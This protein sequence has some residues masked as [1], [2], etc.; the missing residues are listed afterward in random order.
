MRSGGSRMVVNLM[1]VSVTE[2]FIG[3]AVFSVLFLLVRAYRRSKIPKGLKQLPGPLSLPVI[4]HTLSLGN[5][6]HLTLT[7]MSEKYGDIFQ[8]RIGTRPVLVL[9]GLNTLKQALIKQGDDF[10]GRPDLYSFRFISGGES[11]TFSSDYTEVWRLRRK[12]AQNALRSFSAE[13]CKNS[14]HSC[15]LE[16][17]VCSEAQYLVKIF[18]EQ[19][20]T[21]GSFD[22]ARYIVVSVANVICALCFGKRYSHN[23]QELLNIVHVGEEFTKTAASGNPADFIP[24][25]RLLPNYSMDKFIALNKRF[26]IFVGNIVKE[27]YRS[28]DKD[29]IRDITDSLIGHCQD[30]KM[31]ENANIQISDEKIVSIVNDLF[32]AGFETITIALTWSV[33]YLISYP[34]IQKK[35]HKEIDENIGKDRSPR[36]ADKPLLPY[37]EAFIMETFRHSSFLPFTI[38]HCTTKDTSLNGYFVSKNTCVFVNQWQVNHDLT[39]W[40]DP[41]AFH[42]ERFLNPDGKSINKVECEKVLVFGL[43]KRRCIGEP[44]GRTEVFLFLTT[45]IQ[46]LRFEKKPGQD[47]DMTPQYGLTMKPKGC[48]VQAVQ[49]SSNKAAA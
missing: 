45:L 39:L 4:G 36:I 26:M 19:M 17:H 1:T 32:G 41:F 14:T 2:V 38:P 9:S 16:E 37:T 34:D 49:R 42:P 12:L 21:R 29:N 47:F 28:F 6:P 48:E 18:T 10:S 20:K 46:Q 43:G 25:L 22:P 5:N 30:K 31:D 24:I 44:I 35:L 3:F 23:D 40:K 13:E 11:L 15:L 27:H 8:I 7:S 33:M